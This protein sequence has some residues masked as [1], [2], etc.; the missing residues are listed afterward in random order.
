MI[1][2]VASLRGHNL[3]T[4]TNNPTITNYRCRNCPERLAA[5]FGWG[6]PGLVFVTQWGEAKSRAKG[7]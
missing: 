7:I 4:C 6:D 2:A 3:M 5:G 1:A